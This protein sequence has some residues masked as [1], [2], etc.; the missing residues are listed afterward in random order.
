[1]PSILTRAEV[2]RLK[3]NIARFAQERDDRISK[4][5]RGL[6]EKLTNFGP[7]DEDNVLQFVTL[8]LK[9]YNPHTV[10]VEMTAYYEN[11]QEF[12]H[13]LTK[14]GWG[15]CPTCSSTM[16]AGYCHQCGTSIRGDA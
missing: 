14:G 13:T 1:M 3:S 2:D 10:T 5:R 6:A 16:E 12:R 8:V 15:T 11:T 9:S 7:I 4:Y